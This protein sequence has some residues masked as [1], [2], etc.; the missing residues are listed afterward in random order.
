[1]NCRIAA[2]ALFGMAMLA[3]AIP[4]NL[5]TNPG[6]ETGDFTG[7]N[8][9]AA[10]CG[11]DFGITNNAAYVHSGSYAADFAGVCVGSYDSFQ[12]TLATTPAQTY[13]VSFW[14]Q[15]KAKPD[16]P[17]RDLQVFWDGGQILDLPG[18]GTGNFVQYDFTETASGSNTILEFQGYNQPNFDSVDDVSVVASASDPPSVPESRTSLLLSLGLGLLC[19]RRLLRA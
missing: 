13:D 18:A 15:T 10:G 2:S 12:Q 17:M 9:A 8:I 7:W 3:H 11:S 19:V 4:I 1:M 6:F 16:F 14:I 5:V